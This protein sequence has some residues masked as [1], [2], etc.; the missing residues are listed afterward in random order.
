MKLT[1]G[2]IRIFCDGAC[3]GN[4]GPGGWGTIVADYDRDQVRELGGADPRTTNNRME[5]T[6]LLRGLE[7][8][9]AGKHLNI[10]TDSTYV[11]RGCQS[12]IH[13]WR[14]RGWRTQEGQPVQNQELWEAL[15]DQL[16][17]IK[18]LKMTV[19]WHYVRGHVG[20]AGNERVDRIAVEMSQGNHCNLY[21]GPWRGYSVDLEHVPEDTSLPP[22]KDIK[23]KPKAIGYLSLV[24]GQLMRHRSWGA[25]ERRVKGHSGAKFKKYERES[26]QGLI[27]KSWGQSESATIQDDPSE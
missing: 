16:L 10:M 17:R 21:R 22:M 19:G 20:T 26:D 9:T 6:G 5:M 11:I 18:N 4:P 27:L 1:P 12:W 23:D 7:T 3:S 8:V 24:G 13:G 25:C 14:Q 2:E 15:S